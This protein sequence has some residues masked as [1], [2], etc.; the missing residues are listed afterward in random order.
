MFHVFLGVLC[1]MSFLKWYP[2]APCKTIIF[3]SKNQNLERKIWQIKNYRVFIFKINCHFL[4]QFQPGCPISTPLYI[5]IK[6]NRRKFHSSISQKTNDIRSILEK[7][8]DH[9][10]SEL[11]IGRIFQSSSFA[12]DRS[13][14]QGFKFVTLNGLLFFKKLSFECQNRME[15]NMAVIVIT[16]LK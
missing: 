10:I 4:I 9:W 8:S 5:P 1:I 14:T 7:L 16:K 6:A 13:S 15:E 12:A 3:F 2:W 11:F